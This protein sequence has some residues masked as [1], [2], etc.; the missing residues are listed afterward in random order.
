MERQNAASL[1]TEKQKR[2]LDQ[3]LVSL[4]AYFSTPEGTA[5]AQELEAITER[6]YSRHRESRLTEVEHKAYYFI[7]GKLLAESSVSV[8]E[9][10]RHLGFKSSRSGFKVVQSLIKK[11][12]I[13]RKD[14]RIVLIPNS[15]WSS[16]TSGLALTKNFIPWHD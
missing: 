16:E 11:S 7:Q 1:L 14:G 6:I 15:M 3:M 12:I 8:R 5:L 2:G 4:Y 10:S 13:K 9:I